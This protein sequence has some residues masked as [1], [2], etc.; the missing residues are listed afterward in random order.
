MKQKYT[1]QNKQKK[2]TETKQNTSTKRKKRKGIV[3]V[4]DGGDLEFSRDLA[5]GKKMIRI[6]G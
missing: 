5:W 1:K 3:G 6:S 4:G 2:T